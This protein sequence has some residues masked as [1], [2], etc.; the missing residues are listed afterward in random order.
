MGRNLFASQT[1]GAIANLL[2]NFTS[3]GEDKAPFQFEDLFQVGP[4]QKVFELAAHGEGTLLNPPMAFVHSLGSFKIFRKISLTRD[5]LGIRT[6]PNH[7]RR[8]SFNCGW[9][10]FANQT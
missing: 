1:G 2:L 7:R 5:G 6:K 3:S 4:I 8:S 10:P 9:L